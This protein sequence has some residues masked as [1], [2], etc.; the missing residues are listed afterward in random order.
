MAV[1]LIGVCAKG[2]EAASYEIGLVIEPGSIFRYEVEDTTRTR[3]SDPA[4]KQ[5]IIIALTTE[6]DSRRVVLSRK[7][8]WV[9][10]AE[11][12]AFQNLR[13]D[14]A[15]ALGM[16]LD[17]SIVNDSKVEQ[18]RKHRLQ[19]EIFHLKVMGVNGQP[20]PSETDGVDMTSVL[21]TV[22]Q[23]IAFIPPRM[24]ELLEQWNREVKVGDYTAVYDYEV[25]K[26]YE[27]DGKTIVSV[28][29]EVY[30]RDLPENDPLNVVQEMSFNL[31][32]DCLQKTLYDSKLKFVAGLKKSGKI[33]ERTNTISRKLVS[34]TTVD[35]AARNTLKNQMDSIAMAKEGVELKQYDEAYFRI[36]EVIEQGTLF[37]TGAKQFLRDRI[38][39]EWKVENRQVD[40]F[41]F[42]EW[43][44]SKVTLRKRPGETLLYWLSSTLRY[45]RVLVSGAR[46]TI[47]ESTLFRRARD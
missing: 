15:T 17:Q 39:N 41:W 4:T 47:G 14:E 22:A 46:S 38:F 10:I 2:E 24:V 30:F 27:V 42:T 7:G 25:Q 23:N 40:K 29:G 26:A 37:L 18:L 3:T 11:Q 21:N 6:K 19:S 1:L 16:P 12:E 33:V 9:T 34:M 36:K 44:N 20:D 5:S 35:E 8:E 13:V 45:R 28:K 31:D 43:I 32:F